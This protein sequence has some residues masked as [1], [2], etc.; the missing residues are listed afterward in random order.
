[1]RLHA[2]K[3]CGGKIHRRKMKMVA[4]ET[5][6][7]SKSTFFRRK[8]M[9]CKSKTSSKACQVLKEMLSLMEKT[10]TWKDTV[11]LSKQILKRK[12]SSEKCLK[13]QKRFWP[14]PVSKE[15]VQLHFFPVK[16]LKLFFAFNLKSADVPK[17]CI[18][19]L[20]SNRD[21]K[22]DRILAKGLKLDK[23]FYPFKLSSDLI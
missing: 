15:K 16:N 1:M 10:W 8:R 5:E 11:N 2:Y 23:V 9:I 3:R 7:M 13:L 17:F 19:I 14:R 18:W 21:W 12:G 20:I 6:K 22:T 4:P